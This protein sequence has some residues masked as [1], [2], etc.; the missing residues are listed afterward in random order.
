MPPNLPANPGAETAGP[1]PVSSAPEPIDDK[2]SFAVLDPGQMLELTVGF[3]DQCRRAIALAR[4]WELPAPRDFDCLA[5]IGIGGSAAGADILR[6]YLGPDYARPFTVHRDYGVP[7]L[8]TPQ[9]LVFV[10]SY[11]GDTEEAVA[12]YKG[13]RERGA[14]VACVTSGGE[15]ASLAQE[16]GV[17]LCLVPKGLPPRAAIGYLFFPLLI[18]G[19]RLALWETGPSD[20]DET[21]GLLD[22][23]CT[24]LG[25]DS[26]T[27]SNLAKHLASGLAGKV[28]IIYGWRGFAAP[29]AA[30]WKAQFNENAKVP[31]FAN[32]LPEMNHNEI[33]GWEGLGEAVKDFA[34]IL[35]RDPDDPPRIAKRFDVT[36]RLIDE[37]TTLA[38]VRPPS[39]GRLARLL[40]M[41]YLGDFTSVYLAFAYGTDPSAIESIRALKKEM[42][43]P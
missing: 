31:A 1:G 12:G 15:L 34:V 32:E 42:G 11:S 26:P 13:A 2:S 35:L 43:Q 36:R 4:E 40:W 18:A 29:V 14:T 22:Q 23:A 37:R 10:V 3:P 6:G 5:V 19:G 25:P 8:V 41:T 30:R 16:D 27:K 33:M 7:G 38:E 20:L 9:S 28:P 21:A 39:A 17:P 24:D